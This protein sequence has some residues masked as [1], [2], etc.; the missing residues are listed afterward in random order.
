METTYD[1]STEDLGNIVAL[2]HVNTTIPDQQPA[3]LFYV[4]GLGLTRDPYLMTGTTNMWVN[5]GRTQFHLPT[6]PRPQILRGVVGIVMPNRA[7]LL[8]RLTGVKK[9]LAGTSFDFREDDGV[10]E[11]ISP[12]GNRFRCHEPHADFGQINLGIAYVKFD[13]SRG[14]A[15]GI[16][17]FYRDVIGAPAVVSE[18][19]HGRRVR[20]LAGA[21]QYLVFEESDR[22]IPPYDGHHIQIYIANFS[23]PYR[24]LLEYGLITDES[25][26]HQ[27]RFAEV[28]DPDTSAPLFTIEHEVRSLKHPL[29]MRPL[30]NRN[31]R[32][33]NARYA[34]GQDAWV[35]GIWEG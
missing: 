31:P 11:A 30:V 6:D 26:P 2:E 27:Y 13:V 22:P 25:G 34:P 33:T 4:T 16:A 19:L 18:D 5:L 20:V 17:R 15:D 21:A 8:K 7:E 35:W 1:R 32:Q 14:T 9:Q 24:R 28:I 10:V 3:T 23:G 12:W 29:Y